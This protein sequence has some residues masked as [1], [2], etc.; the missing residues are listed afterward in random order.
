MGVEVPPPPA[1]AK[2]C[3]A[4]RRGKV[5]QEDHVPPPRL[6]PFSFPFSG[7]FCEPA[8]PSSPGCS[9]R[10]RQPSSHGQK[11]NG[12]KN[13]RLTTGKDQFL[14]LRKWHIAA[15]PLTICFY[16]EN[17]SHTWRSAELIS[18]MVLERATH[19]GLLGR[20]LRREFVYVSPPGRTATDSAAFQCVGNQWV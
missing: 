13:H 10:A 11:A 8:P 1:A 2:A 18:T 9:R 6:V 4:R 16:G 7:S 14:W 12:G 5:V 15:Y 17:Q 19:A 3:S 20:V